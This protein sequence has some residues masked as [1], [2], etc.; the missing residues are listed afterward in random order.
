MSFLGKSSISNL[1]IV[2]PTDFEA[3]I[4]I[5]SHFNRLLFIK[6]FCIT[7]EIFQVVQCTKI[8]RNNEFDSQI[9]ITFSK[10]NQHQLYTNTL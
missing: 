6:T 5:F 4:R 7:K 1:G 9:C 10:S 8:T 3:N 2:Q